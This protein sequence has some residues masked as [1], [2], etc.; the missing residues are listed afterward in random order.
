MF[1]HIQIKVPNLRECQA[2]YVAVLG[3]LG[4]AVVFE[5]PDVVVGI[6]KN[7]HDMFEIRQTSESAPLST[8]VHVAF[9]AKDRDSVKRFHAVALEL[10]AKDNGSP[11][12]RPEY[13]ENYFAAFVIDPNGHNLE[14]VST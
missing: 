13:E 5:E 3:T 2:F 12:L 14:A 9:V 10:G 6:G 4:Y 8:S 11:G 1:D 7:K